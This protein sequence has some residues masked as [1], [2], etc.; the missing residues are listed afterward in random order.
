MFYTLRASF[1]CS[2]VKVYMLAYSL[3][4]D[5]CQWQWPEVNPPTDFEQHLWVVTT[6]RAP[7]KGQN[8]GHWGKAGVVYRQS[9]GAS[10]APRT[11]PLVHEGRWREASPSMER[12]RFD[13]TH[14]I[15]HC[16]QGF[17][18][19]QTIV[20]NFALLC[21]VCV[22]SKDYFIC[23]CFYVF[24]RGWIGNAGK[25][26]GECWELRSCFFSGN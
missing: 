6:V 13:S 21:M 16:L 17:S 19:L 14:S 25:I 26:W 23:F 3:L 2:A 8:N 10:S 7:T 22:Y 15:C 12:L 11:A 20:D 18:V 1:C 5:P 9:F 24:L 4:L